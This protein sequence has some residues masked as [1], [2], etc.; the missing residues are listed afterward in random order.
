MNT[1]TGLAL[2]VVLAACA[3]VSEKAAEERPDGAGTVNVRIEGVN[4][5]KGSVYASIYLTT[6]GFPE[7]KELA[8]TYQFEKA[9]SKSVEFT[10]E[11]IPAGWLA[12]AV[13]HDEDMNE[14]LTLG[15]LGIPKEAYGFSNNPDSLFGPPGFDESAVR[16]E[17]GATV[18]LV[19]ELN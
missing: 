14:E 4:S 5:A 19:V 16:L 2:G 15:N 6:E 3:G 8:Y 13:L 17:D 11:D 1:L 10:F 12:V 7:D 18:N 9:Q